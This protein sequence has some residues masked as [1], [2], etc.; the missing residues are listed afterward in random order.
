M[1]RKYLF[2][3]TLIS[4]LLVAITVMAV[5]AQD[6]PTAPQK[7]QPAIAERGESASPAA[8]VNESE[9]NNS[10]ATAD[11]IEANHWRNPEYL[12]VMAGMISPAGD[13]DY[14][15][16]EDEAGYTS[17]YVADID[18]A[19]NGSPMD[20]YICAYDHTGLELGCNDDSDG[21]DSLLIVPYEDEDG[22]FYIKVQELNHGN[23][24][25]NDYTYTLSVYSPLL[26]SAATNGTV[27]GVPFQAADILAFNGLKW[28][29]FFDASDVWVS[30]NVTSF[31]HNLMKL[32]LSFAKNQVVTGENLQQY[33]ATPYDVV[34]FNATQWG[35][36]THG[37]FENVL[38]FDGSNY[39]LSAASEKIDAL[40]PRSWFS[41]EMVLSTTGAAAVPKAG[42]GILKGRDEDLLVP[43]TATG[44]WTMAFDGSLL[45]G[46]GTEDVTATSWLPCFCDNTMLVIQGTGTVMG[47]KLTQ[48]DVYLYDVEFPEWSYRIFRGPEHG[49]NYNIDGLD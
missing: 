21:L 27:N 49:F 45:P 24:G 26:I 6:M 40:G 28:M 1:N 22:V 4:L 37:A 32:A 31:N 30:A 35:P 8:N 34:G 25:G 20:A 39:G 15:K 7:A 46:L 42:G 43:N 9:P 29:L 14:Y 12:D 48:K 33:T 17:F 38:L 47:T 10:F 41:S 3:V 19:S 23:E 16:F 13:I 11:Y 5:A 18:A 36:A 44:Q 2:R